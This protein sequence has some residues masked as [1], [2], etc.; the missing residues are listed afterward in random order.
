MLVLVAVDVV[1]LDI[2]ILEHDLARQDLLLPHGMLGFGGVELGH[3]FRGEQLERI[4]DVL[5]AGLACLIEQ[6]H[7]VDPARLELAQLAPDGLRRTDQPRLERLLLLRPTLPA[8]VFL[9]EIGRARRIDALST[10]V[11]EREDEEGP[12]GGLGLGLLVGRRT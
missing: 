4:A 5:M 10:V 9:P 7:L 3:D 11:G 12:A 8:L 6:D 2:E 1:L